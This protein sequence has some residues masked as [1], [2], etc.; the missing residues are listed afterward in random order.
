[1]DP[2]GKIAEAIDHRHVV[3]CVVYCSTEIVTP[4]VIRHVEG[5]RFAIGEPSGAPTQR[6]ADISRAFGA[7]GLKCPVDDRLRDQIWLKLIGNVAFNPISALTRSTMRELG[8]TRELRDLLRAVMDETVAVGQALDISLPVSVDRRF[9]AAFAVGDHRTSMLQDLEAGRPLEFQCMTGAVIELAGI[10]GVDVP[11]TQ[12]VHALIAAIDPANR[13][14][15][16]ASA[17]EPATKAAT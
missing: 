10:L 3:G 13:A 4:G 5:T 6:T 11:S 16:G 8:A 1:V 2:G 15:P 17:F 12:A 7:G 14:R 9:E